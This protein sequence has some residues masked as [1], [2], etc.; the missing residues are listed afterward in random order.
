MK[1]L[2]SIGELA[3]YQNISKQ[4]LIYYDK[5][6]LFPP[7]YVDPNNGY[8]Y[9]SA[10]QMDYLD[11]ILVMKEMG[12]SLAEIQQHMKSYTID[13]SLV[14]LRKQLTVLEQQIA[15]LRLVR[16]RLSHRCA[17]METVKGYQARNQEVTVKEVG[18]QYLLYAPV[19][20]PHSLR[21]ISIATK[22]CFSQALREGLPIYFQTGDIIPYEKILQGRYTE[23]SH[24][25]L[26]I[27]KTKKAPN[28]RHL[29]R[30]KAACIYHWGT[31]QSIDTSYRKLL[32]FCRD[33]GLEILSDAYEFCINDYISSG[34]ENEYI[35]EIFFYVGGKENG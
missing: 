11:T 35:T 19:E 23:A 9:Y 5:I 14:A 10:K 16:N 1:D 29:P 30:G 31:Y 22:K 4:T 13:T 32:S 12:F 3:G 8:R 33:N 24:A 17:Q 7:A 27:E 26:P 6:G 2:F 28:I 21:E 18:P 15:H 34:D 20:P 25:F